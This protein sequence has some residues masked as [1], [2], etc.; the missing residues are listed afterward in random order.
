MNAIHALCQ[1]SYSPVQ[2]GIFSTG[3]VYKSQD[4][5]CTF[6]FLDSRES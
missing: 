5:F 2:I 6:L 4:L 3:S 1:L